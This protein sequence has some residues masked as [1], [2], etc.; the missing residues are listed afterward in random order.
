MT[1]AYHIF[2]HLYADEKETANLLA[3]LN[4]SF[5]PWTGLTSRTV[6]TATEDQ[7]VSVLYI[8]EDIES[9]LKGQ[10][11]VHELI[12]QY[13]ELVGFNTEFIFEVNDNRSF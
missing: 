8:C 13:G 3:E 5:E 12:E 1:F 4:Q 2:G 7:I 11:R 6:F 10:K 9:A